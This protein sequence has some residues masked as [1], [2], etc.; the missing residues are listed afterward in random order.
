[1]SLLSRKIILTSLIISLLGCQAIKSNPG[2]IIGT[3]LGAGLGGF[4]GSKIGSGAGR[5]IAIIAGTALGGWAGS[6]LGKYFDEKDRA[7]VENKSAQALASTKDGQTV[8][9]KNQ[10]NGNSATITP[11]NTRNVQ[12]SVQYYRSKRIE[13]INEI[14]LIGEQYI[15]LKSVN[16]RSSPNTHSSIV[17]GLR[18]SQEFNAMGK[19]KNKNWIVVAKGNHTVGYVYAPLV[20]PVTHQPVPVLRKSFNLDD[21]EA[22]DSTHMANTSDVHKPNQQY[23]STNQSTSKSVDLDDMPENSLNLDELSDDDFVIE[24]AAA[25]TQCRKLDYTLATKDGQTESDSFQA[26][27]DADGSWEII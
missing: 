25:T 5:T 23:K 4:V 17:G 20:Q 6:E 8:A 9:W 16:L 27:K 7:A 19:V 18:P 1:M 26:C 14:E 24:T 12:R 15:A 22:N 13:P 3:V 2:Q 21:I 10:Q 11:S